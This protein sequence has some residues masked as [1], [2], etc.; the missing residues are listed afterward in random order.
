VACHPAGVAEH[1]YIRR[2]PHTALAGLVVGYAGY[3]G[4]SDA[5]LRRRQAPSGGCTLILSLDPPLRLHGPAGPVVRRSFLAG[6]HD[7]AVHTEFTG[8]QAGVQADLT[9][10]GA[11]VL[12][13]RPMPELT[14]RASAL[15]ELGVRELAALPVRL[16]EDGGWSERF[17]RVDAVLLRRLRS[18]RTRPDPEVA[19]AWR[20]LVRS[21][22]RREVGELAEDVGWSRRRL[23]ARFETQIGLGPKVAGRVLRFRR[24]A[25]LL[26]APG[27]HR[28][29]IAGIA[30]ATGYADHSHLVREFRALA[31]CTPT[32]YIDA[33]LADPGYPFGQA[34][35]GAEVLPCVP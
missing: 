22:G 4:H 5:P 31:G 7:V 15:D 18:S 3:R 8:A 29:T 30:A 10:L 27:A 23:L 17:D 28:P 20:Q 26:T 21:D 6:M 33:E 2:R 12:L 32:Q 25:D 14:N 35:P 11:H 9:P 24:A 13:D 1:E 34:P 16:G 19:W